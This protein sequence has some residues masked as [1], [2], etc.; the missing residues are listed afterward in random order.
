MP[1][2]L[3]DP[4]DARRSLESALEPAALSEL[5]ARPALDGAAAFLTRWHRTG[6]A[7]LIGGAAGRALAAAWLRRSGLTL[8]PVFLP[9]I[10]FLGYANDY[11]PAHSRDWPR[12]FLEASARSAEWGLARLAALTRSHHR[13]R[14]GAQPRRTT[15]RLPALIDLIIAT[16]AITP[17]RAAAILGISMTAARGLLQRLAERRLVREI[18]G[19]EA[20]RVYADE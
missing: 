18:T 16:P 20:F 2:S 6:A 11:D 17:G 7:D 5:R 3:L 1:D 10:G 14:E 12:S 19:R 4:E 8:R 13:L 9:A 15:S